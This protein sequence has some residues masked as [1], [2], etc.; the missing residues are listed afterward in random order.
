MSATTS[1]ATN[2]KVSMIFSGGGAPMNVIITVKDNTLR[3]TKLLTAGQPLDEN[4]TE[5]SF[6]VSGLQD[7][8]KSYYISNFKLR[9]HSFLPAM[10]KAAYPALYPFFNFK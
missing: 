9:G 6:V 10:V 5:T 1:T 4:V 8:R 3:V 2:F 7:R